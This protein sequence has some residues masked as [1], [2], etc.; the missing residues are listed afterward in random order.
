[1]LGGVRKRATRVLLAFGIGYGLSRFADHL[2]RESR[3]QKLGA[4]VASVR[5]IPLR[6]WKHIFA[7][8][9]SALLTGD[10]LSKAAAIAFYA[11]LSLVPA[12][13]VLI[14]IYGLFAEPAR[15][16]DQLGPFLAL[17]PEAAATLVREQAQRIAGSPS[18]QLSLT[19]V[20]SFLIA[21]WGA[22]S[23]TKALFD[24]LNR[25]SDVPETR[26]FVRL[27]AI[28]LLTTLSIAVLFVLLMISLALLPTL[29][30]VAPWHEEDWARVAW[31]RWPLLGALSYALIRVTYGVGLA[32]TPLEGD[33]LAPGALLAVVLG[34]LLSIGFGAY[35]SRIASYTATYGSLATIVI[36][37]TWLWLSALAV[38]LGAQFNASIARLVAR[39]DLDRP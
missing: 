4:G 22:N 13:S 9:F 12:M 14:T 8:C 7:D 18:E 23:A 27:N 10:H 30:I 36:F 11:L 33:W 32:K 24:T 15:V 6:G 1:M 28:S 3:W 37:L 29:A 39:G 31:L 34:L 17:L 25:I 35:V 21:C 26:S 19:L 38:I 16:V 5:A 2:R 20:L